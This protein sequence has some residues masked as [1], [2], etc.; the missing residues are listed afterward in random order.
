MKKSAAKHPSPLLPSLMAGILNGLLG[1]GGGIP[2]FFYLSKTKNGRIAYATSSVGILLLS[3]QT[4]FLYRDKSISIQEVSPF[5]PMLAISGGALGAWL[6]GKIK[7]RFLTLVFGV[8]LLLSG[9]YLLG[10]EIFIA[11]S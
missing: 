1:T 9:G 11:L 2:L 10:K 8:L 3:L 5:L 6:C 7:R 4:V